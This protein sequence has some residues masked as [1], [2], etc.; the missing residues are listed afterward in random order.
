M[1]RKIRKTKRKVKE[2]KNAKEHLEHKTKTK[3]SKIQEQFL[4]AKLRF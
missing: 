4:R 1:Q 2:N 3:L